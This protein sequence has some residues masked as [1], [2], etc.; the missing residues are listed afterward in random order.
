MRWLLLKDLQILRRSPL[1]T[2]LLVLYPIA[3]AIL[4]GFALS[5]GPEKPRVAFVNHVPSGQGFSLGQGSL[6]KSAARAQLCAKVECVDAATVGDARSMVQSGDVLGALILPRNLVTNLN[7]LKGLTASQPYVRVL[8]NEEDPVKAQLVNDR[9]SSLITKA[10]LKL[11]KAVVGTAAGYLNLVVNGG[12][13][14]LLG[15]SFDILGLRKA[16]AILSALDTRL[17]P[18]NPFA[19]PLGDVIRFADLARQNLNLAQPILSSVAHPIEVRK[20]VV[21]GSP[22]SLDAFAIAVA[23]TVTLMFVTVLLVAGSLALEREENAFPRLTRGLI[24]QTGLLVEKVA[25]GMVASLAVTFVMLAGL[26][27]FVDIAWSRFLPIGGAILVG[28]AAWAAFG[29]AIGAAAREVRASSL[30]AFMI[31]LPIA[32]LSLVP[33]GTVGVGIYHGLQVFRALFPFHAAL[34]ALSAGLDSGASGYG[35]A[36][37]HLAIL[38]LAYGILARLAL[39][40]FAT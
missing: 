32:F 14:N 27:L 3:I 5:R 28:G 33:S 2:V 17:G 16:G 35:P 37:L 15:Q 4:I 8:V 11:S 31:S 26:S 7:S 24:S 23:A 19:Q 9:I 12:H 18:S 39:R 34:N 30:L 1:V 40:R 10:N 6:D 38:T 29:A 36:L 21:S 25:L 13:L 22:P 20:Q